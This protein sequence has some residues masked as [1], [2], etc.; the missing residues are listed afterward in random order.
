[1]DRV[2]RLLIEVLTEPQH[3]GQ[4]VLGTIKIAVLPIAKVFT[5]CFMGFL[6]A[7]KFVNILPSN[8][9]KLLNGVGDLPL[10]LVFFIHF[11]LSLSVKIHA[12]LPVAVDYL[13]GF[14]KL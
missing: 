14:N 11:C 13:D 10:N 1:M 8:G 3:G 7:S 6:M 4:S 12:F 2:Q 9:R 5:M